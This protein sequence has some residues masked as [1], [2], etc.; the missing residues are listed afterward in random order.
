[1]ASFL[2]SINYDRLTEV[3]QGWE[4]GNILIGTNP[5]ETLPGETGKIPGTGTMVAAIETMLG[6][7]AEI[8]GETVPT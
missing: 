8:T 1:M 3:L 4:D 5:D 6:E 7:E 2:R